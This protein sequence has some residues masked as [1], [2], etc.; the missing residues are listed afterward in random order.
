MES[1]YYKNLGSNRRSYDAV[2]Q[3]LK[4]RGR[5]A[6]I[7][8]ALDVGELFV[9]VMNDHPELFYVGQQFRYS[10]S[11]LGREIHP[12]YLYSAGQVRQL[13]AQLQTA[14][15]QILDQ[16]INPNQSDYD[17]VRALHDY[18]KSN[19]EYDAEL[20]GSQQINDSRVAEIHS[21]VGGLLHHK[22]VCEGFAKSMKYLCDKIGLEC[23]VVH[24]SASSALGSGPHAWNIVRIGG[25]YHH[26]D[27]TWDHQYSDSELIPNYGYLNLSD[28]EIARD[29]T[30]N[31]NNFPACPTAPYNYFH[32]NNALLDSKAQLELLLYNSFQMEEEIVMFRVVRGSLLERE[33]HGCLTDCIDRASQRCKHIRVPTYQYGGIAEQLTFFVKPNYEY[34]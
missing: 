7:S 6:S 11:L 10:A 1:L 3:C 32:I 13:E 29:H 21:V 22:C 19:L 4:Q 8:G 24:G 28:E 12:A 15:Q 34:C 23:W 18:L 31:K 17:R 30:W 27:V 26:V 2:L 25:Y 9:Q 16:T 5:S 33:V 20:A 14:A